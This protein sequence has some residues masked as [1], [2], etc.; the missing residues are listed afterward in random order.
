MSK[1]AAA[2]SGIATLYSTP[3][4]DSVY[5][6]TL[7]LTAVASR[8]TVL[9]RRRIVTGWNVG[10]E[11]NVMNFRKKRSVRAYESVWGFQCQNE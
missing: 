3:L 11:M 2:A 10:G 4:T 6:I 8:A 5:E 9:S 1:G 7:P